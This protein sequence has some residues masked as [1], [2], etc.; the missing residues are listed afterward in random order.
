MNFRE[1]EIL[2]ERNVKSYFMCS[3]PSL[4]FIVDV[5]TCSLWIDN[6]NGR[7][8]IPSLN[9]AGDDDDYSLRFRHYFSHSD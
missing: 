5:L 7:G 8:S 9:R 1:E 4:G 3:T 2:M 6:V